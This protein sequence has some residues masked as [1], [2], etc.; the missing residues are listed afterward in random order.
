MR[1]LG[2]AD[3]AGDALGERSTIGASY[4]IG[5]A[6]AR[7]AAISQCLRS[8]FAILFRPRCSSSGAA[9]PSEFTFE[10]KRETKALKVADFAP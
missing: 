1:I 8:F 2:Y 6:V 10:K 5:A 7:T 9:N 3:S 4:T